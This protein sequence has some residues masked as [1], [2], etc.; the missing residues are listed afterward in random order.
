MDFDFPLIL[1]G[2]TGTE[3]NKRGYDGKGP[4]ELWTLDHPEA[5]IGLQKGY[6][7]S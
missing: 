1:D 7:F 2:A 4:S 5:V 3:L 6:I